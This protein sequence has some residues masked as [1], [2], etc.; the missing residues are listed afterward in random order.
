MLKVLFTL[1]LFIT[2]YGAICYYSDWKLALAIFI[3]Q[4]AQNLE[5]K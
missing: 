4:W 3:L 2:G 1:F 5:N